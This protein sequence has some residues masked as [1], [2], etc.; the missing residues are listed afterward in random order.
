MKEKTYTNKNIGRAISLARESRK[1]T[2]RSLAELTGIDQSDISKIERG[3]ANPSVATLEKIATAL[4]STLNLTLD[5]A[6]TTSTGYIDKLRIKKAP[7]W[8]VVTAEPFLNC[9]KVHPLQQG[10]VS[11][12]LK[13]ASHCQAVKEVYVFGS[14]VTNR[15]HIG[16]DVDIYMI[17]DR[18]VNPLTEKYDFKIDFWNN[19]RVDKRLEKEIIKKGV[20]VY[21]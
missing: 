13:D 1:M 18:D 3:L 9:A 14:S 19:F 6:E 8:K 16:S 15:C 21:G 12:I 2:Q 17:M 10:K 20:K 4:G 5:I 11:S 7:D